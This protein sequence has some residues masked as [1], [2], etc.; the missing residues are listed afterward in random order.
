M[1]NNCIIITKKTP[2]TRTGEHQYFQ[3]MAGNS[4]YL[5]AGTG[6]DSSFFESSRA[7]NVNWRRFTGS[8]KIVSSAGTM[9]AIS[10]G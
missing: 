7:N 1:C 6:S 3:S 4:F 2:I 8:A 9:A 10:A 5:S